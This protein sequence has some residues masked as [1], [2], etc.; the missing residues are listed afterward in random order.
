MARSSDGSPRMAESAR[1][2]VPVGIWAG[3]DFPVQFVGEGIQRVLGML[4][5]GAAESGRVTFH[6]ALR[7]V[8]VASGLAM[9]RGLRAR[10]GDSWVLHVIE[11]AGDAPPPTSYPLMGGLPHDLPPGAK[12]LLAMPDRRIASGLFVAGLAATPL[13]ML[14]A[15]LRPAWRFAWTHGLRLSVATLRDPVTAAPEIA[16]GVRHLPGGRRLAQALLAWSAERQRDRTPTPQASTS[17]TPDWRIR[18]LEPGVPAG[19]LCLLP[20]LI[21]P[22]S[23]PGRRFVM[24]P[25]A[26]MLD[27]TSAW[28]PA[29]LAP[30]GTWPSW[31]SAVSRNLAVADAVLTISAH[32]AR[33][34]VVGHLGVDATKLRIV[35]VPAS[36][37]AVA[38]PFLAADRRRTPATRHEAAVMLRRHAAARDWTYLA[39][40]P[41]EHVDYIAVSTQERPNKNLSLLIEALRLIVQERSGGLKLLLTTH[42]VDDPTTP[43]FRLHGLLRRHGLELDVVSLPRLPNREL[44]ALFHAAAVTVLPS[45]FEG[46]DVPLTFSE[47]VGLGTPSL[48]ARGPHTEEML[49][50]FPDLAPFVFDPYD[51]GALAELITQSIAARDAV[52]DTQLAVY[53]TMRRR[54]W[55]QAAEEYAT[56]VTGVPLAPVRRLS[57]ADA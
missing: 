49:E 11:D 45:M 16:V 6:I 41:L 27:F 24:L 51:A 3:W 1:P 14:R 38:L 19:W 52:L 33:N 48:M 8:N 37:L 34:H 50:Q 40:F 23:I 2:R 25:D 4:V 30:G 55:A 29:D 10:E 20:N 31:F 21:I 35:P 9:L 28:N 13:F 18:S 44:A 56:V 57:P 47:S 32:V 15:L 53:A 17:S 39:D 22:P 54:G 42:V 5:E 46:G 36:D 12:R 7:P 43:C 26:V